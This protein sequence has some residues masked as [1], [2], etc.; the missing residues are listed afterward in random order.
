MLV[1]FNSTN[2]DYVG[3][4]PAEFS[5]VGDLIAATYTRFYSFVFFSTTKVLVSL[6]YKF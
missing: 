2:T 6:S 3:R 4:I 1:I 5:Q